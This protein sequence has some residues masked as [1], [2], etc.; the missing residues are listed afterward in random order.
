MANAEVIRV[1][2]QVAQ[3]PKTE[4]KG[5]F[6]RVMDRIEAG[7]MAKAERVIFDVTGKTAAEVRADMER[8]SARK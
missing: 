7:Q 4:R 1:V 5:F 8:R 2:P 6:G 3:E